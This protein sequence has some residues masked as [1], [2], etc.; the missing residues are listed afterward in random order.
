VNSLCEARAAGD[1][2][3]NAEMRRLLA[4]AAAAMG[5]ALATTGHAAE[6]YP[7]PMAMPSGPP[8]AEEP[9]QAAAA[10]LEHLYHLASG[11]PEPMTWAMMIVGFG[12]AGAILRRRKAIGEFD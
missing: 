3:G 6:V 9:A 4:I 5:L 7:E 12:A 10:S 11:L 2:S 8:A 1:Q